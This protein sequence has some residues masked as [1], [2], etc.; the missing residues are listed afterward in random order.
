MF[1]K[2]PAVSH[3]PDTKL[4]HDDEL[5]ILGNN[6]LFYLSP[7]GEGNTCYTNTQLKGQYIKYFETP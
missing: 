2:A 6:K 7:G 5:T 4:N 1:L 3:I